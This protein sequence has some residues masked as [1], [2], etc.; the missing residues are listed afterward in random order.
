MR[1]FL[2]E[3]AG[4]RHVAAAFA[5]F[6]AGSL[7]LVV[8]GPYA[9]YVA[10]A[11]RLSLESIW[12]YSGEDAQQYLASLDAA[13][14]ALYAAWL[15]WDLLYPLFYALPLAFVLSVAV[16]RVTRSEGLF[17]AAQLVPLAAGGVDWI[18]DALLLALLGQWPAP[19]L[20]TARAAAAASAT[21]TVL[22]VVSVLALAPALAGWAVKAARRHH[23]HP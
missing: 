13:Q 21:K 15:R 22:L 10:A 20:A 9:R 12:F 19:T 6:A 18:E 23:G 2:R 8:F 17:G 4:V 7:S 14:R 3:R 16:S 11:G 1:A 5:L